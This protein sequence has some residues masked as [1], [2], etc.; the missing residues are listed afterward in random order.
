[1][2][3]ILKDGGATDE[4]ADATLAAMGDEAIESTYWQMVELSQS[5]G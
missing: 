3:K 4:E 1:M 5:Q 2:R